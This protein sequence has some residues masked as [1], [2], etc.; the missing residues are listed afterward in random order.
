MTIHNHMAGPKLNLNP[1]GFINHNN[2]GL[3]PNFDLLCSCLQIFPRG[4]ERVNGF[5]CGACVLGR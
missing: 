2:M 3:L 1:L 4:L 5:N